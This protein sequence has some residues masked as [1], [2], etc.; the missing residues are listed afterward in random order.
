MQLSPARRPAKAQRGRRD[1]LGG[2]AIAGGRHAPD[3]GEGR[4]AKPLRLPAPAVPSLAQA[5]TPRKPKRRAAFH[6]L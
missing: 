6:I 5:Q 3:K 1:Q 2:A 4:L